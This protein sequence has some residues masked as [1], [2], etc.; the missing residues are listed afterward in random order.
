MVWLTRGR[1]SSTDWLPDVTATNRT[2]VADEKRTQSVQ[3]SS[4][5]H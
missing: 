1:F 5:S 2:L 4:A 3:R